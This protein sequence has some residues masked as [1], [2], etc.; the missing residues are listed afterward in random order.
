MGY[1]DELVRSME[2]L[3]TKDETLF[4]GQSVKYSGNAIYNTKKEI[5]TEFELVALGRWIGKTQNNGRHFGPDS[6]HIGILYNLAEDMHEYRI[7]PAFVDLY[8]ADWISQPQ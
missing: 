5:F 8:N 3:A 6:G 1:K 2:W 4:I 7:S